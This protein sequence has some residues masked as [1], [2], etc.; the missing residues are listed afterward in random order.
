MSQG[1]LSVVRKVWNIIVWFI[2]LVLLAPSGLILASQNAVPGDTMYPVKRSLEKVLLAVIPSP[3]YQVKVKIKYTE[4]RLKEVKILAGKG[5]ADENTS[6]SLASLGEQVES[7]SD[8]IKKVSNDQKQKEL[9]ESYLETLVETKQTLQNEKVRI[10]SSA[11]ANDISTPI[12]PNDNQVVENQNQDVSSEQIIDSKEVQRQPTVVNN[13]GDINTGSQPVQVGNENSSIQPTQP[14][15][16]QPTITN[17]PSIT[18]KNIQP[19]QPPQVDPT[20]TTKPTNSVNNNQQ[21]QGQSE[22]NTP[23]PIPTELPNYE[24]APD[25]SEEIEKVEKEVDE[26]IKEM[27]EIIKKSKGK[28][29][30]NSSKD[31]KGRDNQNSGKNDLDTDNDEKNKNRGKG[32]DDNRHNDQPDDEGKKKG[33]N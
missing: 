19:T 32:G 16:L 18:T 23:Q 15:S 22:T 27:E 17:T 14:M 30:K 6:I 21:G 5:L 29:N 12:S 1:Y 26:K 25:P 28:S 33:K 31:K 11:N 7:T 8:T 13:P 4:R 2:L 10:S 9:A 24:M 20:N 3:F